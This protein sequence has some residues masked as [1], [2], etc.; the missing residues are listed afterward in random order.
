M[1]NWPTAALKVRCD[2]VVAHLCL[3]QR[4]QRLQQFVLQQVLQTHASLFRPL[5][6][7]HN[8]AGEQAKTTSTN[9][10]CHLS[11]GRLLLPAASPRTPGCPTS[12]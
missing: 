12:A 5:V 2:D 10:T 7:T 9:H 11:A 3:P 4:A 8:T 1:I 6:D